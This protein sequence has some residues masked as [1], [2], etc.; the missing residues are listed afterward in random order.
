MPF[1]LLIM[2]LI[3]SSLMMN[4]K[5]NKSKIFSIILGVLLS[6]WIYY[7]N[8]IFNLMGKNERLPI[9]LSIWF[10]LFILSLFSII[11]LVKINEK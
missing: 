3:G 5:Y 10:P 6:V 4:V 7:L 8:Y 2:I 1:Y 11:G 9:F